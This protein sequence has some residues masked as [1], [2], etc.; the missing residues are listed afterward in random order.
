MNQRRGSLSARTAASVQGAVGFPVLIA[1]A[2]LTALAV[3]SFALMSARDVFEN[4]AGQQ[5]TQADVNEA[6]L[7]FIG[8]FARLPCPD[9]STPPDGTEDCAVLGEQQIGR[10]PYATLGLEG[11]ASLPLT[12]VPNQHATA[13]LTDVSGSADILEVNLPASMPVNPIVSPAA[14]AASPPV[15]A[16]PADDRATNRARVIAQYALEAFYADL[17]LDQASSNGAATP[18]REA[19]SYPTSIAEYLD[20]MS[21]GAPSTSTSP[22]I[23]AVFCA[24]ENSVCVLPAGVTL[25]VWYGQGSNWISQVGVSGSIACSNGVFTDPSPGQVKKCYYQPLVAGAQIGSATYDFTDGTS[26][27]DDLEEVIVDVMRF[28]SAHL[29]Q[30]QLVTM[31]LDLGDLNDAVNVTLNKDIADAAMV[32]ELQAHRMV[33]RAFSDAL[34]DVIDDY[35]ARSLGS[36]SAYQPVNFASISATP[37]AALNTAYQS[38]ADDLDAY[39]YAAPAIAAQDLADLED[40]SDPKVLGRGLLKAIGYTTEK[41]ASRNGALKSIVADARGDALESAIKA[42][43][44]TAETAGLATGTPDTVQEFRDNTA[45]TRVTKVNEKTTLEGQRTSAINAL[46]TAGSSLADALVHPDIVAYDALIAAVENEILVID[47]QL[48]QADALLPHYANL[49]ASLGNLRDDWY[50]RTTNGSGDCVADA[51]LNFYLDAISEAANDAPAGFTEDDV[52][53]VAPQG[54]TG[55]SVGE[56]A[57]SRAPVTNP[58]ATTAVGNSGAVNLA[59]FCAK[60]DV[61]DVPVAGKLS[62]PSSAFGPAYLLIDHGAD[63]IRDEANRLALNG[64]AFAAV[65]RAHDADYDDTVEV[66]TTEF[67]RRTL[68]CTALLANFR[69]FDGLVA[70]IDLL[71]ADAVNIRDGAEEEIITAAVDVA[72]AVLRLAVD[73]AAIVQESVAGAAFTA[74]CIASLGFAAN[75]CAAAGFSF[76]AAAAH[77]ATVITDGVNIGLTTA[78]LV[79][80]IQSRDDARNTVD[81]IRAAYSTI[82]TSVKSA[83]NRG[84]LTETN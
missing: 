60:L 73:I 52:G 2:G 64:G 35:N 84:G 81:E 71:Y 30:D 53:D 54:N 56:Q 36:T 4:V 23:D 45:A 77:G 16:A 63:R 9:Q 33:W 42:L 6:I 69:T 3:A 38:A 68:G 20:L 57:S 34:E 58:G 27:Y 49:A 83:D 17:L 5:I 79:D 80:A 44:T 24:N 11:R 22:P 15:P 50:C 10:V 67:L 70:D 62:V 51:A 1:L 82:V 78:S 29:A 75:F 74:V 46:V 48:L 31:A 65:D 72:L 7:G 13:S 41:A 8:A 39:A 66:V 32:V 19:S 47:G 26:Y 25:T 40:N 18:N 59:D 28:L 37:L 12:Y 14:D 55:F 76:A 61:A 21:A 43:A